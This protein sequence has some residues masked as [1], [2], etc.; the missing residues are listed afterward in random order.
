MVL[1]A[2]GV[3][4]SR[5]SSALVFPAHRSFLDLSDNDLPTLPRDLSS[6]SSLEALDVSG[7]PFLSLPL[8]GLASLPQLKSLRIDVKPGEEDTLRAVLPRLEELRGKGTSAEREFAAAAA[9]AANLIAVPSDTTT[10]PSL[11]Q[12]GVA[13]ITQVSTSGVA[14]AASAPPDLAPNGSSTVELPHG[15]SA[16][17]SSSTG[18]SSSSGGISSSSGGSS[19]HHLTEDDLSSVALLFDALRRAVIKSLPVG[20]EGVQ[21]AS[22]TTLRAAAAAAEARRTRLAQLFDD[23]VHSTLA[24]LNDRLATSAGQPFMR[25]SHVVAAKAELFAAPVA[26][27]LASL[28]SAASTAAA[29]VP[30][31]ESGRAA[32][33]SLAPPSGPSTGPVAGIS[34]AEGI[35]AR[36][37]SGS[38]SAS[39]P[40]TLAAAE[41][42]HWESVTEGDSDETRALFSGIRSVVDA[43][44]AA[45]A[46]FAATLAASAASSPAF[47]STPSPA[48]PISPLFTTPSSREQLSRAAAGILFA[49]NSAVAAQAKVVRD[50]TAFHI[51]SHEDALS[52]A[53]SAREE[54]RGAREEAKVRE[55]ALDERT[56]ELAAARSARDEAEAALAAVSTANERQLRSLRVTVEALQFR[57]ARVDEELEAAKKAAS[58]SSSSSSVSG[59]AESAAAATVRAA[60]KGSSVQPP[61]SSS[62]ASAAA[63]SPRLHPHDMQPPRSLQLALAARTASAAAA[64]TAAMAGSATTTTSGAAAAADTTAV[65]RRGVG[66]ALHGPASTTTSRLRPS[67]VSPPRQQQ[68]RGASSPPSYAALGP[69]AAVRARMAHSASVLAADSSSGSSET[70]AAVG[71]LSAVSSPRPHSPPPRTGPSAAAAPSS[72]S[73]L[74]LP[75]LRL[76][77]SGVMPLA[78]LRQTMAAL[79]ASKDAADAACDRLQQQHGGGGGGK[80]SKQGR[81]PAPVRETMEEHLHAWL[82]RRAPPPP[83]HDD[84]PS[85]NGALSASAAPSASSAVA[86]A[87]ALVRGINAWSAFDADVALFG[88]LL[89]NEVDEGY[90]RVHDKLKSTAEQLL[91]DGLRKAAQ[92]QQQLLTQQRHWG[93]DGTEQ[94]DA[95]AAVAER[96]EAGMRARLRATA[97][98]GVADDLQL[99]AHDW[100][101]LQSEGAG[102]SFS[103]SSGAPQQWGLRGMGDGGGGNVPTHGLPLVI[104]EAHGGGVPRPEWEPIVRYMYLPGHDAEEATALVEARV[105]RET[106]AGTHPMPQRARA[107]AAAA[108]RLH[109]AREEH[110]DAAISAFVAASSSS[111]S[112]TPSAASAA[113][114]A[115][116]AAVS[117]A[118]P[119]GR[120]PWCSFLHVLL[121]FQ[122]RRHERFLAKFVPLFQSLDVT[123]VGV[124]TDLQFARLAATV[125]PQRS[126]PGDI[127]GLLREAD[128][129][130]HDRVT[131]SECVRVLTAGLTAPHQHRGS[132]GVLPPAAAA[133]AVGAS[134]R[135]PSVPR[136]RAETRVVRGRGMQKRARGPAVVDSDHAAAPLPQPP[137]SSATKPGGGRARSNIPPRGRE[138]TTTGGKAGAQRQPLSAYHASSSAAGAGEVRSRSV[139]RLALDSDTLLRSFSRS[140]R[141][142][143]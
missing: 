100:Q 91:R 18:S 38:A 143:A 7:N 25:V 109:A 132:G 96:V 3:R 72:P 110:I 24:R 89:R 11:I 69:I 55:S 104:S 128:P 54:A 99:D 34:T 5:S 50:L 37:R 22:V 39:D 56:R 8:H 120:I 119:E 29:S 124:L 52:S 82:M 101:P 95:H 75:T 47:G 31:S 139:P 102:A 43:E 19:S 98:D 6:L 135:G 130:G 49:L 123:G 33:R 87:A 67:S 74:L 118:N 126:T 81:A 137:W 121:S 84:A 40:I 14:A 77:P 21:F 117:R 66:A 131:F 57:Q 13:G 64:I 116:C 113:G 79:F 17:L 9:S 65:L 12:S 58:S 20:G 59:S 32:P 2:V 15:S 133:V 103:F 83:P 26:L 71:T 138:A 1:L 23:H 127:A 30:T 134:P 140:R 94:E 92:V 85:L 27:L 88:R 28:R 63:P 10:T 129:G 4:R 36:S 108:G 41:L 112:Q 122:L 51:E 45:T 86:F 141:F 142:D 111:S 97:F 107:A 114:D 60:A 35:G 61:P 93:E 48:P 78:D 16:A 73:L 80:H 42:R 62:S 90:R 68:Q 53:A 105:A 70:A 125:A 106:F 44:A 46:A 76:T 136:G 115:V